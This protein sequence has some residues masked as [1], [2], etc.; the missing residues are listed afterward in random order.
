MTSTG[1]AGALIETVPCPIC[2]GQG[3]IAPGTACAACGGIGVTTEARANGYLEMMHLAALEGARARARQ[4]GAAGADLETRKAAQTRA[5]AAAYYQATEAA[6]RRAE[7]AMYHAQS[8]HAQTA[9]ML[10]DAAVKFA[11][12]GPVLPPIPPGTGPNIPGGVEDPIILVDSIRVREI[13]V[14]GSPGINAPNYVPGQGI[15][16]SGDVT[17]A[18]DSANI[19]AQLN[20]NGHA[21][22]NTSAGP[23]YIGT[24]GSSAPGLIVPTPGGNLA[25]TSGGSSTGAT[26]T[27]HPVYYLGNGPAVQM[28]GPASQ[29]TPH[30]YPTNIMGGQITDIVFDGSM[31]GGA[32]DGI[33]YGN[34]D[35]IYLWRVRC[36]NFAGRG[37]HEISNA[38]NSYTEKVDINV[39]LFFNGIGIQY[40]APAP[41]TNSH[42]YGRWNLHME[43]NTIGAQFVNAAGI[44]GGFFRAFGNFY[45]G[46]G[47][48]GIGIDFS[49]G[50]NNSGHFDSSLV[51]IQFE[52]T[53]SGSAT[54]QTCRFGTS[55]M[56]GFSNCTGIL[57][58]ADPAWTNSD[59]HAGQ[60]SFG[61]YINNNDLTLTQ[62]NSPAPYGWLTLSGTA[63]SSQAPGG[64]TTASTSLVMA[65]LNQTFTPTGTGLLLVLMTCNAFT[66]S[67][68]AQFTVGAR[69]GTGAAPAQGTAVTG[70]RI[71]AT[72]EPTRQ[73]PA[74][75]TPDGTITFA[76]IVNA[77]P[78]TARW[79][80]FAISTANASDTV[81]VQNC[82]V[83]VVEL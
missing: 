5:E 58:F 25:G 63:P 83:V 78:G 62:N 76:G 31:A 10:D 46:V 53:G 68:V 39:Q 49:A 48:N 75:G 67:A 74:A 26:S 1:L 13:D 69:T 18:T 4:L 65:G 19:Q 22:I 57:L 29:G 28:L 47:P 77:T 27:P 14:W 55:A 21:V 7:A 35:S 51:V 11:A 43:G 37:L 60:I 81:T 3:Q 44:H 54:F 40:D 82:Q 72:G 38:T 12:I 23:F 66:N 30:A 16:P 79:F 71:N 34:G 59:V 9:A 56:A 50:V 42:F 73:A 2:S 36:A 24:A 15:F 17:G 52:T 32:A 70:N 45:P 6:A 64:Y 41:A 61:G 8:T 33:E 20:A 80:D